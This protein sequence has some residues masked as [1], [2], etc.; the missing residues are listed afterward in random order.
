M[1]MIS[2]H[3]CPLAS[4]EGKE[5]G[6]L[7][8]YVL[9]LSKELAKNGFRVDIFTR[10]QD[11]KQPKIVSL[12]PNLRVIHLL[13]GPERYVPK[14]QLLD[15]IPEFVKNYHA[16]AKEQN[17]NYDLLHCHYY[18][19]GVA[20]LKIIKRHNLPLVMTFHT[21]ALM[22]NLVARDELEKEEKERVDAEFL[23]TKKAQ[24]IIA[25]SESDKNYLQYLYNVLPEK[26]TVVA[27]GVDTNIFKPIDKDKAKRFIGADP[28]HKI[29]LFVGRLEP[30]K[31][32]D[33]LLYAIKI[34][35]VKKRLPL[36]LWIVGGDAAQKY[37]S[38]SRELGKL[39]NLRKLL[40][41]TTVVKFLGQRPQSR[42]PYYYNSSEVVV[43]PSHYESFGIV[44]LEAMACGVPVITTNVSGV[45]GLIDEKH[46]SLIT[47]V[48]NP[49][50]LA[51]QI[52]FLLTNEKSHKKISAE[53]LKNIKDLA[54]KNT[55]KGVE[56]VYNEALSFTLNN[57]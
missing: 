42:L 44:A 19:S 40:H 39:E 2:F 36:C 49:L 27:P 22:K 18:L 15:Y 5:T 29:V 25:P 13:A 21:L 30:L 20:G 56:A 32:I 24:K 35:L 54:W 34:L 55:A 17:T 33:V 6:G 12:S 4:Q 52:E 43:I 41:L 45:A 10:S 1:A 28:K 50:L 38:R 23:L 37:Q 26:I 16:F 47:S 3:T 57:P 11:Q 14:K 48:N 9:E 8:V 31:G 7:N 53:I 46:Q 51:M